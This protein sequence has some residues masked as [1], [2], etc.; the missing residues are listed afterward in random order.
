MPPI[1]VSASAFWKSVTEHISAEHRPVCAAEHWGLS[2][3]TSLE[4]GKNILWITTKTSNLL[5]WII[6]ACIH[7]WLVSVLELEENAKVKW[8]VGRL[9]VARGWARRMDFLK[10]VILF[11][12]LLLKLWKYFQQKSYFYFTCTGSAPALFPITD[13]PASSSEGSG[14]SSIK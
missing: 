11:L 8:S 12:I 14:K 7:E 9:V 13:P 3:K 10:N 5:Y 6:S 4:V 1:F 2:L